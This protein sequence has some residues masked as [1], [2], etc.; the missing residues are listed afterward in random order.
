MKKMGSAFSGPIYVS[1]REALLYMADEIVIDINRKIN[2][3]KDINIENN[4]DNNIDN[5][6]DNPKI[7]NMLISALHSF[8]PVDAPNSGPDSDKLVISNIKKEWSKA[9]NMIFEESLAKFN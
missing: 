9:I 1:A 7:G 5:N 6:V 8:L 2:I 3:K 4:I